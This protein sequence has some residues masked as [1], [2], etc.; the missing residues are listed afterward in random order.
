M[1]RDSEFARDLEF[2]KLMARRED[3]RLTDVALELARDA[4]P[5][6]DFSKT[7]A[8][9]SGRASEISSGT[10]K[11]RSEEAAL[12]LLAEC[13]ARKYGLLGTREAYLH[14]DSSYVNRVCE[15]GRGIP[16]SL[17]L[18]Y[19]A[20]AN[21][22]GLPLLGVAAPGHFMTRYEA[23]DGPLFVDAFASGEVLTMDQM[24]LRVTLSTSCSEERA[25]AMLEPASTRTI[26]IRML[27]NLKSLYFEQEK[28]DAAWKVQH[29]LA[30]LQPGSYEEQRDLGVLSVKANRPGPAIDL[31]ETCLKSADENDAPALE[32]HLAEAR[33]QLSQW[34]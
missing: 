13:L 19:M 16:I 31:L 6:L 8:W 9:I 1:L 5:N 23:V 28:W 22:A 14:A 15:T 24:L 29:R 11:A 25:L 18:V 7:H 12:E 20:V 32:S 21:E 10:I 34:N 17:S 3:V 2:T 30:A 27:N 26:I 4:Y 33:R